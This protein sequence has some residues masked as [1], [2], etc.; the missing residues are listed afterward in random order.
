MIDPKLQKA[1]LDDYDREVGLYQDLASTTAA[2]LQKMMQGA[3]VQL[4]SI[5]QRCKDRKSLAGKLA[6]PEKEYGRLCEV[7]DLAGVRITTYFAEDVDRVAELVER[8]FL[9]DTANSIDKRQMLDPDRFGYQS[10][11]YVVSVTPDR[12]QLVEYSHFNALRFEIQVRSILQH[13]WAEIEHDLGYKSAAGVP[14]AIRRRFSRIAGLLELADDEFSAI[15]RELDDYAS[16]MPLEIREQPE[17][18]GIDKISLQALVSSN[19]S[20]V[21]H[22]SQAVAR[23]A[24][25]SLVSIGD[26]LLDRSVAL[27]GQVDISSVADL[28]RVADSHLKVV[29]EF[30]RLWIGAIRYETMHAGIGILYLIYVLLAEQGDVMRIRNFVKYAELNGD[31]DEI[32]NHI[33]TTYQSAVTPR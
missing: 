7:T 23:V 13:A 20:S 16:T 14:R 19:E 2:L 22:L 15:R 33:L 10:L 8:E 28:E 11:H 31:F 9:I 25:A 18:V 29:E 4:H 26:D 6:K 27:L 30:A 17:K 5:T 12:C 32:T 3:G 1:M 21:Y 24:G